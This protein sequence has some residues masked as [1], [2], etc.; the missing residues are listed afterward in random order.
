MVYA[1]DNLAI[2]AH[3]LIDFAANI[4]FALYG[5]VCETGGFVNQAVQCIN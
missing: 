3:I 2:I 5:A 1:L 4:Q